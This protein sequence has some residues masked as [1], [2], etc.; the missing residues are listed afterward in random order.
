M[1][2][3]LTPCFNDQMTSMED[4]FDRWFAGWRASRDLPAAEVT[5]DGL[6][7]H[8]AQPSR[9]F[10]VFALHADDDPASI[11][12]LAAKVLAMKEHTWLTLPTHRSTQTAAA[13]EAAGMEVLHR[14]EWLMSI[15]L[16]GHPHRAPGPGYTCTA[17]TEGPAIHVSVHDEAGELAA[18]GQLGLAG[19]DAVPDRIETMPDHR[20]RGLGSVV[21]SALAAEALAQGA[22]TGLLIASVDGQGLY[23]AL[24]W[25]HVADVVISQAPAA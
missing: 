3:A 21:M 11:P 5:D 4:L 7:I 22:R 6:W 16:T 23:S 15:D 2:R 8:C 20:R 19:E 13:V 24:G 12:R 14:S 9:E 1:N 18:R 17:R 25:E 10:E